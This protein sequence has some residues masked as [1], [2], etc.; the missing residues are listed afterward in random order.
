MRKTLF[1]PPF[2]LAVLLSACSSHN[3]EQARED[4]RKAG[5]EVK[6]DA[7]ELRQKVDAAVKPDSQ[8]ASDKMSEGVN[9][10]E[11]AGSRAA[12]KL[13]RAALLAKVKTK[14][15]ADAGLDT[16]SKVDVSIKGNVVILSGSVSSEEQK[17]AAEQAAS[18]VDG[19]ARV[20]NS[21]VVTH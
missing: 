19:V 3:Q 4:A 8:S 6:A 7:K 2:T 12:V 18:Q 5:S 9:K 10:M 13:D 17:K 16:L 1:L 15:A 14:L 21:L 20:N 11:E